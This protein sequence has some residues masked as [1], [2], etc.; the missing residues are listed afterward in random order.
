MKT[1]TIRNT[2]AGLAA[3]A[4]I[5]TGATALAG[6]SQGY[7][8][9]NP[10]C[11][12]CGHYQ[13]GSGCGQGAGNPNLT[14]QQQ[15]QLTAERQAFMAATQAQRQDL[16]AKQMALK[17]E[18]AKS[19]PDPQAAAALQKEISQLASDLDQKRLTHIMAMRKI[20]PEAGR[21]FFMD[22]RQMGQH[23]RGQGGC[24]Q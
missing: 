17:A 2:M 9:G 1:S 11:A 15:E 6:K 4:V 8:G 20:D 18:I 5:A 23:G 13:R 14:E 10:G 21:G 24:R 22:G 19:D 16:Y 3:L 7:G 12:G